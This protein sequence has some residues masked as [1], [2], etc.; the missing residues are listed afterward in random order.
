[1]E[2]LIRYIMRTVE[3]A[4]E[5]YDGEEAGSLMGD[6]L[7]IIKNLVHNMKLLPTMIPPGSPNGVATLKKIHLWRKCTR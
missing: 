3:F 6:V 7:F 1:M 2:G 4:R 5:H